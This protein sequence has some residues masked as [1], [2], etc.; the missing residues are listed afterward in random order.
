MSDIDEIKSMLSSLLDMFDY[1]QISKEPYGEYLLRWFHTFKEPKNKPSSNEEMLRTINK[2][3]LPVLGNIPINKLSG[4]DIQIFLNGMGESN[5]RDKTALILNGSL[6]KAVKLGLLYR[7]PFDMVEF[8]RNRQ[9][10]YFPLTY[11]QQN[12]VFE[13]CRNVYYRS[14]FVFLV[15]TGL[16]VGEFLALDFTKPFQRNVVEVLHSMDIKT[17]KIQTPK[18]ETSIRRVPYLPKLEQDI[19]IIRKAYLTGF[20][21]TY[22]SIKCYF[23]KIYKKGDIHCNIHSFRHTFT[24]L[25]YSV[26]MKLKMIQALLGHSTMEVTV[27]VYTHLLGAG[28]SIFSDYFIEYKRYLESRPT[29]ILGKQW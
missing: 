13:S 19:K 1:H 27:N 7:N 14:C 15:C 2:N 18:T 23:R 26:D 21:F 22:N 17:G 3:I 4:E 6:K 11:V 10:H 25:C 20:R 28:K 9:V 24:S 5:I 29:N 8:R 16:R 12:Y